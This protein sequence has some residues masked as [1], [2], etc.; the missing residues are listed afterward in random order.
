MKNLLLIIT[1]I[2]FL[3]SCSGNKN[4]A[5]PF[6]TDPSHIK[7]K[8]KVE[9]ENKIIPANAL[10]V[11][12]SC[13]LFLKP[14]KEKMDSLK[15]SLSEKDYQSQVSMV[16]HE[17]NKVADQLDSLDIINF[18]CRKEIIILRNADNKDTSLNNDGSG[19]NLILFNIEKK[20]L[21]VSSADFKPIT[22]VDY[23]QK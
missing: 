2:F 17:T 6:K 12:Q 22:A 15:K 20:P 5:P 10:L 9:Y 3:L 8:R 16:N 11:D 1:S 23:F 19:N 21:I 7:R 4:D 13:V 18:E 14:S